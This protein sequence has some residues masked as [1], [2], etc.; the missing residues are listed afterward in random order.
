MEQNYKNKKYKIKYDSVVKY[1]IGGSKNKYSSIEEISQIIMRLQTFTEATI[2][3]FLEKVKAAEKVLNPAKVLKKFGE[4]MLELIKIRYQKINESNEHLVK[5]INAFREFFGAPIIEELFKKCNIT[6]VETNPKLFKFTNIFEAGNYRE[7]RLLFGQLIEKGIL[8]TKL[9]ENTEQELIPCPINSQEALRSM[10]V[11]QKMQKIDDLYLLAAHGEE[12]SAFE[13]K[14]SRLQPKQPSLIRL[15]GYYKFVRISSYG[16]STQNGW[17]DFFYCLFTQDGEENKELLIFLANQSHYDLEDKQKFTEM[18]IEKLYKLN[19]TIFLHFYNKFRETK[20]KKE[21]REDLLGRLMGWTNQDELFSMIEFLL[22]VEQDKFR[23]WCSII[24]YKI[25]QKITV[26]DTIISDMTLTFDLDSLGSKAGVFSRKDLIT[27]DHEDKIE[28]ICGF[29]QIKK[30]GLYTKQFVET[31]KL[32]LSE[33]INSGSRSQEFSIAGLPPGTYFLATCR[34]EKSLMD[35]ALKIPKSGDMSLVYEPT[36]MALKDQESIDKEAE[37]LG[38]IQSIVLKEGRRDLEDK[39]ELIRYFYYLL[40]N[41]ENEEEAGAEVDEETKI[42]TAIEFYEK[43]KGAVVDTSQRVERDAQYRKG[44]ERL[45]LLRTKS[46]ERQDLIGLASNLIGEDLDKQINKEIE[47][48]NS[49]LKRFNGIDKYNIIGIQPNEMLVRMRYL[50]ILPEIPPVLPRE[51][52]I[53]KFISYYNRTWSIPLF[54]STITPTSVIPYDKFIVDI[55]NNLT[56]EKGIEIYKLFCFAFSAITRKI[57]EIRDRQ[58]IFSNFTQ[59][60][61]NKIRG[62]LNDIVNYS[63]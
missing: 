55:S 46:V 59:I 56:P 40:L 44:I 51:I 63:R 61:I 62:L 3:N 41:S 6:P 58:I 8:L 15:D 16:E 18:L 38:K 2:P 20:D 47:D 28:N 14:D 30:L 7:I 53:N 39:I 9:I 33:L 24:V 4:E 26:T 27:E 23:E 12:D 19:V 31:S 54:M 52:F 37:I 13:I 45:G 29:D 11:E 35:N 48:Y 1:K 60:E 49:I 22:E 57:P 32:K 25:I 42:M 5:N 10:L 43:N 36:M 34:V 21:F 50:D 17:G